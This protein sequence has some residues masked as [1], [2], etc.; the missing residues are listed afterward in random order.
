MSK[1]KSMEDIFVQL[2]ERLGA[3]EI[4]TKLDPVT[5]TAVYLARLEMKEYIQEIVGDDMSP[6]A[7]KIRSALR[8]M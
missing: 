3:K 4:G 2:V 1:T 6:A 7:Q 8:R 5:S